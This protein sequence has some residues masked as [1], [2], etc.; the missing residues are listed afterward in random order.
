MGMEEKSDQE[1][2]RLIAGEQAVGALA[3]LVRRYGGLVYRFAL[4]QARDPHLAEDIT[5]AVF[6][7]LVQKVRSIRPDAVLASW[8]F[9]VTRH[10][11]SNAR[12]L[13][14][15]RRHHETKKAAM[16]KEACP[17]TEPLDEA[18]ESLIFEA[19]SK[20]PATDQSA[21]VLRYFQDRTVSEVAESLA[22]SEE[23]A[24]KRLSRALGKLHSFLEIRGVSNAQEALAVG[25]A[26][27]VSI[28][29]PPALAQSIVNVAL[30]S[31]STAGASAPAINIANKVSHMITLMHQL[32][33]AGVAAGILLV[34][35][36]AAAPLLEKGATTAPSTQPASETVVQA[37]PD[38]SG[39]VTAVVNKDI[40]IHILGVSPFEGDEN[41]WFGIDGNPIKMPDVEMPKGNMQVDQRVVVQN[42]PNG[43]NMNMQGGNV[44]M[45]PS[46]TYQLAMRI[47]KPE[48]VTARPRMLSST[49]GEGGRF[50][51]S[52][53]ANL[54]MFT[55]A[56]GAQTATLRVLVADAPWQTIV[57]NEKIQ[58]GGEFETKDYGTIT[59]MPVDEQDL[60]SM[61]PGLPVGS[62]KRPTV[63]FT[64]QSM[65]VPQEVV[66]VDDAGAE[67][68]SVGNSM[69]GTGQGVQATNRFNVPLDKIKK[70]MLRVRPFTKMV[71]ISNI[72]L[73]KGQI[74]KPEIKIGDAPAGGM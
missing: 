34:I 5:Q 8:F 6:I 21:V 20:L 60:G 69:M 43:I 38:A 55:P 25:L 65:S 73:T 9:T 51:G 67:H 15:R 23:A 58:D 35:A 16:M 40:S 33:I 36:V 66:V 10:A 19:I 18:T 14:A 68:T 61:M 41:S 28:A 4:R 64:C 7:V 29:T 26:H 27:G 45:A 42:L 74:T 57:T 17:P 47:D 31:Q 72:S 11:V 62:K 46:P 3:E 52:G 49:G 48:D 12:R 53:K 71:E 22:V 2:L 13:E 44:Q 50:G 39:E 56:P 1:I 24:R 30:I 59:F 70:V 37:A 63:T 54:M 32:K